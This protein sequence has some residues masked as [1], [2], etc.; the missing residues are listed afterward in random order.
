M[1]CPFGSP[2]FW[3]DVATGG[4][5]VRA[6]EGAYPDDVAGMVL[7]DISSEP[8][9]PVYEQLDCRP[10]DRRLQQDRRPHDSA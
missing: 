6:F 10:V 9:V 4:M 8:E 1:S 3:W 7:I 2:S 5:P